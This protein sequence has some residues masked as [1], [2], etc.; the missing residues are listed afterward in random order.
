MATR[1]HPGVYIEEIPSGVRPIEGVSTSNA[2]FIGAAEMGPLSQAQLVTSFAEFQT[3]YGE[4]RNDSFLAPSVFQFFN[5]GGKKTYIVRVAGAGAT[6]AAIAIK[7][8]KGARTL[9]VSAANE[10]TWGN[11][12]SLAIGNDPTDPNNAFSMQ[13]L[14][15]RGDLNPPLPPQVL[16]TFAGLV[17]D[18]TSPNFVDSVVAAKSRYIKA[19]HDDANLATAVRGISRS[20]PMPVVNGANL[21]K[22]GLGNGGAETSGSAAT[23]GRSVS[24]PTPS[25]NPA[26]NQ[27]QFNI[28]LDGDG[29]Q[30]VTIPPGSATGADIA[31]AIAAAVNVMTAAT[32]AHQAAYLNFACTFTTTYNLSSGTTGPGSTV[33]VTAGPAGQDGAPVLKLGL[34]NGGTE[35]AGTAVTKGSSVSGA[36]PS[37]NPPADQRKLLVNLDNDGAQEVTISPGPK[38]G[39]QIAAAIQK[40]VRSMTAATAIHQPAY[41]SFACAF[42]G[43]YTLT[44]GT[45][46]ATSSVVVTDST[47]TP[48]D[49][50]S[51]GDPAKFLITINGDGPA[52]VTLTGAMASLGA[53]ATA[54][55]SA[56]QAI[57]PQRSVNKDAFLN[58]NASYDISNN[59]WAPAL[60]LTSGVRGTASSVVVTNVVGQKAAGILHLGISNG[61]SEIT[62]GAVLRPANSAQPNTDFNLGVGIASTLAKPTNIDSVV[63]GA[64]GTPPHDLEHKNGLSAL[65]TVRDVNII[66]IP[67]ISS[68]DVVSTGTNYC[69]QRGDCFFIGDPHVTDVTVDE[70]RTFANSLTVKSSFGAIYYPWPQMADPTGA[71]TSPVPVP[72]S[73][74]VAG[75]YARIDST[76]GVWKAPAGTEANIAGAIGLLANTTDAQQDFLNPI[77]V[78]VIRSFP[79]A[80]IVIWGARTLATLS[81]PE[82]RYIPVRRTAIFLE[83]SIYNG[84]QYAVFEPNDFGLWASLRMNIGAFM[85]LQFRAGAFQGKTPNDAFFVKVDETTTTQQDIDAGT[86][87]I[88]V[89]FAP[90]KPAE[91]VVL[92]LTQKAGQPA[93]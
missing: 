10:G 74:F 30:V 43:T 70:I 68:A 54:I 82:Y 25:T 85:M 36:A 81:N 64:D 26:A 1:L 3:N 20:T 58:F 88:L 76:R 45:T 80:G 28:N 91:F 29:P 16:E 47:A 37:T 93:V 12:L 40:A 2:A 87:N 90:L 52:E 41:D 83:Q 9:Q 69:A 60:V 44:S 23:P 22:L 61:G 34:A 50:S 17:M 32:P 77:G 11:K 62:G 38:T 5:N 51:L 31:A 63:L 19:A 35:N 27:R 6:A 8:R 53:I 86:V 59:D 14:K 24:G 13:V 71:S 56:V 57:T 89:G 78:N 92:K 66:C 21:L 18:P 65:D 67:G 75:M 84:I 73:G 42:G 79:A 49:T 33:V 72:P 7:D 48:F 46:G 55:Q 39:D 4:F 15:Y